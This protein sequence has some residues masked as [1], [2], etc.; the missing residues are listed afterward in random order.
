MKLTSFNTALNMG[1]IYLPSF[2]LSLIPVLLSDLFVNPT[3]EI[4]PRLFYIKGL[5]GS[6]LIMSDSVILYKMIS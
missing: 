4:K 2:S 5:H 3:N 1:D 6:D